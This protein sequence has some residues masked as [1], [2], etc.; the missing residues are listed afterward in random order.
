VYA[1]PVGRPEELRFSAGAATLAGT[2]VLPDAT[3]SGTRYPFAL[4]I[5][6]WLPRTRDGDY[7]RSGH[8]GWFAAAS[9]G[10]APPLLARL[11][12][13]LAGLGVA[14]LRWDKRGCAASRHEAAS[15]TWA[16][17]DLFTLI[18]DA[19]DAL[20]AL[21]GRS[22]LDLR[23]TGIVAHGEGAVI[24]LSV[25]IG[26]PAVG[27]LT[28][29]GAPARSFRDVLRR[30]AATR[31]LTGD[32][33]DHPFVA[34]LDRLAEELIEATER[35]EQRLELSPRGG[36][37]PPP[38]VELNLAA[39]RQAFNTPALALATMFTRSLTLVHGERDAWSHP[40]ESALLR[41]ALGAAGSSVRSV[42]VAGSG[43]DL[44]EADDAL[45]GELAADLA[46]RLE[47]R[48]LPPVLLAIEG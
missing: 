38:K 32:E 33:R 29:I 30:G 25:A 40:D 23:R 14:S 28:L 45:I 47:P 34:T 12:E 10:A 13:E 44:A 43:H 4:L 31:G 24:A 22:D 15:V 20:A 21:R 19:R 16:R 9:P 1:A 8:P 5:G 17:S 35:G 48:E 26:D 2:L 36:S 37:D 46:R 7:D 42:A 18:D 41:E 6:S 27:P 3:A 39:F 11:A